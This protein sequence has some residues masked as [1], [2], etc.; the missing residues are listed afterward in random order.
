M[1]ALRFWKKLLTECKYSQAP[2][3]LL[4]LLASAVLWFGFTGCGGPVP[5]I[6]SPT[7]GHTTEAMPSASGEA[8]GII[9]GY[10][11]H[12]PD[13][14]RL[15]AGCGCLRGCPL[16]GARFVDKMDSSVRE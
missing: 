13:G 3:F 2:K 9:F 15:V 7:N 11:Y 1:V 12:R 16:T 4:F 6:E 8:T 10:T 14:N 5:E